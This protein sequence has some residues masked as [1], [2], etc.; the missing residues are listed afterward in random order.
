MPS[1]VLYCS[2]LSKMPA[3]PGCC[4]SCHDDADAG[5]GELIERYDDNDQLTHIVCC[6][7][8]QWLDKQPLPGGEKP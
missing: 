2:D 7:V 3:F 8:A 1:K 4:D 5:Y 6:K